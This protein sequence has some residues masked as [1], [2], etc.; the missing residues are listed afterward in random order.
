MFGC[1]N[2]YPY[3]IRILVVTMSEKLPQVVY[4]PEEN[5][6]RL[7]FRE[8]VYTRGENVD[9]QNGRRVRREEINPHIPLEMRGGVD[10]GITVSGKEEVLGVMFYRINQGLDLTSFPE[11]QLIRNILRRP[12]NWIRLA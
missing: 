3:G 11:Q 12:E 2:E 4:Y 10:Y 8:G 7:T 1:C 6:L 5:A 9:F